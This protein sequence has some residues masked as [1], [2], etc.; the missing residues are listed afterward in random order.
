MK[1]GSCTQNLLVA[2]SLMMLVSTTG[3][4]AKD[5]PAQTDTIV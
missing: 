5:V 4:F 1:T 3:V 2:V